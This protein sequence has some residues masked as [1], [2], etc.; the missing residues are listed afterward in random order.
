MIY[1]IWQVITQ[2]SFQH[3]QWLE[4]MISQDSHSRYGT[5]IWYPVS[6]IAWIA[7]KCRGMRKCSGMRKSARRKH[8][9]VATVRDTHLAHPE[10]FPSVLTW[11]QNTLVTSAPLHWLAFGSTNS[12]LTLEWPVNSELLTRA[13]CLSIPDLAWLLFPSLFCSLFSSPFHLY[14]GVMHHKLNVNKVYGVMSFDI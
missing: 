1:Y 5:W 14:W 7:F 10:M 4:L 9:V 13:G 8:Q 2:H 11:Y 6:C 3:C 12:G